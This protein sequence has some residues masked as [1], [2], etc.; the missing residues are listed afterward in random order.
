MTPGKVIFLSS[1]AV[2]LLGL[3]HY[4]VRRLKRSQLTNA[5]EPTGTD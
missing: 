2:V 5:A 4:V 3:G 1:Y